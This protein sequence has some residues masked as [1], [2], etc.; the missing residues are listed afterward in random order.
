MTNPDPGDKLAL[1]SSDGCPFCWY[2]MEA[3]NRLGLQVEMRD[4]V[5][6]RTRLVELIQGRGRPTVPVL[7]IQSPDGSV[8]WMPESRDIIHY[9]QETYGQG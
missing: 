4:I 9:L 6:D 2:V 8:R 3:I 5:R 7:W 1:Y